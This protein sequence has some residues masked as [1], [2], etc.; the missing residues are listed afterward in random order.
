[1]VLEY[2]VFA[3]R[4]YAMKYKKKSLSKLGE[5]NSMWSGDEVS[6][7]A[8]H[9]WVRNHLPSRSGCQ[10]CGQTKSYYDL[11]NVTGIYS[12]DFINWQYLC[13]LCHMI[14]DGRLVKLQSRS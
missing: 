3:L 9:R 1:M 10:M 5:K 14:S 11:A 2:A 12:R 8:V 6:Y 7:K 4:K 13:R